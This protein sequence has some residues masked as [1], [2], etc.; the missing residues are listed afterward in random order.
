MNVMLNYDIV[1]S[2][3]ITIEATFKII[4]VGK[5][6]YPLLSFGHISFNCI[7]SQ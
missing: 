7:I 1:A 2:V 5:L 4:K 3:Y 6:T